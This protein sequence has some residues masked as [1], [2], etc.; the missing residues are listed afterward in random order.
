MTFGRDYERERWLQRRVNEEERNDRLI[1]EHAQPS[2]AT[3]PMATSVVGRSDRRRW[4]I[5]LVGR[6][7]VG[8]ER[9]ICP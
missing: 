3:G 2:E 5:V 8:G 7:L 1:R 9:C 4:S 6:I